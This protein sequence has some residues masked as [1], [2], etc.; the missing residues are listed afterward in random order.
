[1]EALDGSLELQSA[2]EAG[3]LLEV[4]LPCG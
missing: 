3:T 2:A 1:V 4:R